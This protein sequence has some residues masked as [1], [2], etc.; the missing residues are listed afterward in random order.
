LLTIGA[1]QLLGLITFAISRQTFLPRVTLLLLLGGHHRQRR[2]ESH[3][4]G[5]FSAFRTGRERRAADGGLPVEWETV[6]QDDSSIRRP[7][8]PDPGQRR[9]ADRSYCDRRLDLG[10][11]FFQRGA[12]SG[13]A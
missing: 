3:F 9:V 6:H 11:P 12:R 13:A 2:T 1:I 7:H 5:D 4:N 8:I 10:R